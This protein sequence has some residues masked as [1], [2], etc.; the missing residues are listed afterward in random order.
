MVDETRAASEMSVIFDAGIANKRERA[1]GLS[2][3]RY[4]SLVHDLLHALQTYRLAL[5][6]V[7]FVIT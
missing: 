4:M 3:S 6:V 2:C 7:C 5:A 1:R